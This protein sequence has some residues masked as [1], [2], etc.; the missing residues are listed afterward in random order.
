MTHGEYD[1]SARIPAY[2]L[3]SVLFLSQGGAVRAAEE[4]ATPEE[5]KHLVDQLGAASKESAA[6]AKKRLGEIGPAA[7]AALREA[8]ARNRNNAAGKAAQAVVEEIGRQAQQTLA[9]R[10]ARVKVKGAIL[11]RVTEEALAEV[12]PSHLFLAVRFPQYPVAVRPRPPLKTHNLFI[13]DKDGQMEHVTDFKGLEAFW[14]EHIGRVLKE[15][16]ARQSVRGWLALAQQF[17][18]DGFYEFSIPEGDLK[19]AEVSTGIRAVGKAVIKPVNGNKGVI[20]VTITYAID[21]F[22]DQVI[23]NKKDIVIGKRPK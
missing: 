22:L 16:R 9:A 6:R 13:V 10:L 4:K 14:R 12:F 20:E 17:M 19:A 1:M 2:L 5:V 7:L 18:Q 3:G 11:S 21:G 23:E 15:E 8:I